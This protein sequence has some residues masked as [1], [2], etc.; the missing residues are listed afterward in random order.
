MENTC[1]GDGG[2]AARL[3]GGEPGSSRGIRSRIQPEECRGGG[4]EGRR[5]TGGTDVSGELWGDMGS[6][7]C[8]TALGGR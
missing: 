3:R 2:E 1:H 6:P 8:I 5:V 4:E 7:S